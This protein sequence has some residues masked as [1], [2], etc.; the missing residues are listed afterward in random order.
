VF[1]LLVFIY[2]SNIYIYL[3]R[4][5]K[6]GKRTNRSKNEYIKILIYMGPITIAG[7]VHVLVQMQM[8]NWEEVSELV[9][10]VLIL[11]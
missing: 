5:I 11:R 6:G 4:D 2:Y 7:A 10:F 3:K 9:H 1:I 8:Q